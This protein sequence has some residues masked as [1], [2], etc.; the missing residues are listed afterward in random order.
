MYLCTETEAEMNTLIKGLQAWMHYFISESHSA[1][2]GEV[3][4][5][6]RQ[7]SMGHSE[8]QNAQTLKNYLQVRR[9]VGAKSTTASVGSPSV[10]KSSESGGG[11][12]S[13]LPLDPKAQILDIDSPGRGGMYRTG[14]ARELNAGS[15]NRATS[16]VDP[17]LTSATGVQVSNAA[18]GSNASS[19]I[20]SGPSASG[21]SDAQRKEIEALTLRLKQLTEQESATRKENEVLRQAIGEK[22]ADTKKQLEDLNTNFEAKKRSLNFI[23]NAK[24]MEIEKLRT[25]KQK[26]TDARLKELEDTIA[27]RDHEITELKSKLNDKEIEI[28]ERKESEMALQEKFESTVAGV[29][30]ENAKKLQELQETQSRLKDRYFFALA[31]SSPALSAANHPTLDLPSIYDRCIREQVP[32]DQW[33]DWLTQFANENQ[34][35]EGE[36]ENVE[37]F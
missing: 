30:K 29:A 13:A 18:V 36:E 12:A 25:E 1:T 14:S 11:S 17:S 10:G 19:P 5:A 37:N 27:L 2:R 3:T 8:S 31:L 32:F 22:D 21:G 33:P 15:A 34:R 9:N 26:L 16:P 6:E 24:D 23:V 7:F 20:Q 4:A 35:A 28:L